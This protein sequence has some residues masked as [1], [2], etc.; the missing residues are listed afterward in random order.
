MDRSKL[1]FI[2]DSVLSEKVESSK[3]IDRSAKNWKKVV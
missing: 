1:P 2:D 3:G